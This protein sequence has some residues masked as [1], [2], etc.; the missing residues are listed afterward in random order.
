MRR[1]FY[2]TTV[3]GYKELKKIKHTFCLLSSVY[4]YKRNSTDPAAASNV[5]VILLL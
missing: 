1:S 4:K 3:A 5:L 2:S